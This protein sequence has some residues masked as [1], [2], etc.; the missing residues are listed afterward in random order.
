MTFYCDKNKK[1]IKIFYFPNQMLLGKN[2]LETN[3]LVVLDSSLLQYLPKD[4]ITVLTSFRITSSLNIKNKKSKL[5]LH[6]F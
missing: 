5:F 2:L 6:D 3:F 4:K 1:F